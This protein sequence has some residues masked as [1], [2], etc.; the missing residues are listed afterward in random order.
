MARTLLLDTHALLWWLSGDERLSGELRESL[1][2]PGNTVLAS[3]VSAWEISIK[4]KLGKLESPPDLLAAVE[5]SGLRW[6]AIEPAEAYAAGQLPMHHR[7]PFD[8]LL[9]A[10]ATARSAELVSRDG[11]LD[12]Y[13]I[14]RTWK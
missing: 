14:V 9:I 1:E 11:Q 3:S 10:Q 8:R 4:K 7:D 2:D 6:I 12:R 5:A 13:G